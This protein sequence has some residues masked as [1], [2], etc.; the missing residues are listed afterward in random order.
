MKINWN[1]KYSTIS[2]YI[3]LTFVTCYSIYKFTNNWDSTKNTLL[4][5]IN[6]LMPF[7]AALMFAYFI[8][9]LV[10]FIE[11]RLVKAI[12]KPKFR[13]AS[14]ILIAYSIIIGIGVILLSFILP[15][16]FDSLIE[17]ANLPLQYQDEI[18]QMV[19]DGSI[20]VFNTGYTIDLTIANE[21]ITENIETTFSSLSGMIT[22]FTPRLLSYVTNFA[23]SVLNLILGM[24]IAIYLLMSKESGLLNARKFVFAILP[25][26]KAIYLIN[27]GKESNQ[28]FIN[29]FIGKIIDSM[30]IGIICFVGL[31]ILN[32]P[33]ALLLSVVVGITNMIPYFGP[34]I[35]GFIGFGLLLFINP[36]QALWYL[37]F[38]L[39]LQQFDGNIL[40]PKILGDSTGLSAF[41]VI[42]A[43][44]VFGK[45][46]GLIGM[47][48]GVPVFAVIKNVIKRQIDHMYNSR[49]TTM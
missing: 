23:S 33:Y 25:P 14:S 21:Y 15:Q 45:L 11:K 29:F 38:I 40:G 3:I 10:E 44:I 39:V 4:M 1:N 36:I 8:N 42:F 19:E 5:I 27:L 49:M 24:V 13:R 6:T 47:F 12:K 32:Y 30:I 48:L 9:P 2:I 20:P 31:L 43:I 34:F 16:L 26:K 22:E 46:F 17:A 28:I 37:V 41:W 18:I 35:G 7:I